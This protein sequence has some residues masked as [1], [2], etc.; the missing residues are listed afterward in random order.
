MHTFIDT[1]SQLFIRFFFHLELYCFLDCT[2]SESEIQSD[3][4]EEA[5][6]SSS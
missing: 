2:A 1:L 5:H 3:W 6:H 4:H